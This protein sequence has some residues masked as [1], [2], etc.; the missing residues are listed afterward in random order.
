MTIK[1]TQQ[2]SRTSSLA[3]EFERCADYI[4]AALV[5]A[6]HSHTLQ[7]VWQAISHRQAA[8]FPY[9][10]S[11]IVV[12]IVDYPQRATCRIWLAGGDMDELLEAEKQVCEWAKTQGCTSMEIIGRKGWERVLKDYNPTATVLTKDM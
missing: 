11:A 9:E 12:E 8:F 2:S 10:K 3:D 5:Y 7:D 4:E 6:G 1:D